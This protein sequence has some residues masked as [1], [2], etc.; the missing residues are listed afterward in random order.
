MAPKIEFFELWRAL[1]SDLDFSSFFFDFVALGLGTFVQ[2][3]EHMLAKTPEKP[4][5][6][7][8]FCCFSPKCA[9]SKVDAKS[10]VL[11]PEI[12]PKSLKNP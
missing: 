8:G 3:F 9:F 7:A 6:F 2:D 10:F 5:F 12:L 11:G 1:I 4:K